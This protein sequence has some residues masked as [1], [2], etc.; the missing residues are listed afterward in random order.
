MTFGSRAPYAK[1]RNERVMRSSLRRS[2]DFPDSGPTSI[3]FLNK[4]LLAIKR[5]G[6][7]NMAREYRQAQENL[8]NARSDEERQISELLA[9]RR[10]GLRGEVGRVRAGLRAA[11][12]IYNGVQ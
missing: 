2:D 6:E 3:A 1:K 10:P 7:W 12:Q 9:A 5:G 4:K 8:V 11:E